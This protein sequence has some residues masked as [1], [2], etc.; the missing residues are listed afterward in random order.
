MH[1]FERRLHI[2]RAKRKGAFDPDQHYLEKA[3]RGCVARKVRVL[4]RQMQP[5]VLIAPRWS[6]AHRFLD[7]VG[8][9]LAVGRPSI[10][11]RT[12]SMAPIHGRSVHQARA[13]LIRGITEFCGLYLTGPVS[14][15]VDRN[16]FRHVMRELLQR[17][18]EGPRRALL[19]HGVEH[20]C[21]EARDDLV[22]VFLHHAREAG[23]RRRLNLLLAASVSIAALDLPGARRLMLSDY[24]E[25]EAL[26][27]LTEWAGLVEPQHM[28]TAVD[29]LGGVPA[30]L[31]AVG[32]EAEQSGSL[33]S[34]HDGV[35]RALGSLADEVRG[36]ISIAVSDERLGDRLEELARMGPLPREP[37]L[38]PLLLRAGLI[39]EVPG[40]GEGRVRVRAPVFGDLAL[41]G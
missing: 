35:W 1:R 20:L 29:L 39:Q 41:V 9:D 15:A 23:D 26:E 37:E 32:A 10:E 18:T 40:S 31:D 14:Q 12:L 11:C 22:G 21:V 3:R 25:E 13:W 6:Q 17:T 33:P 24:G 7:D 34:G 27:V 36:A 19:L 28:W 38:D 2:L 5:V 8:V 16:G 4:L 30:L